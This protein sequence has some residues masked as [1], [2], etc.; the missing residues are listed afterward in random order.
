MQGLFEIKRRV[1]QRIVC[2]HTSNARYECRRFHYHAQHNIYMYTCMRGYIYVYMYILHT[3]CNTVYECVYMYVCNVYT[4][5]YAAM[6]NEFMMH[7][8]QSIHD[9]LSP[10]CESS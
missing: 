5:M 1:I 8:Y 2:I 3:M 9:A 10:T 4:G 7:Q 6:N